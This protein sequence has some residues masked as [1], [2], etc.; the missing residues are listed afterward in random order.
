[1]SIKAVAVLT[2]ENC[3]TFRSC[4]DRTV[5]ETE[6]KISVTGA[7]QQQHFTVMLKCR[8]KYKIQQPT[9]V[10]PTT[11]ELVQFSTFFPLQPS[12][13]EM[14]TKQVQFFYI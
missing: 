7:E 10:V 11:F 9:S 5:T 3:H 4:T 1:M 2:E 8:N 13:S 12:V 6:Q 14:Y